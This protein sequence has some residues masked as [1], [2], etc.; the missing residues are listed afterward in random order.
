MPGMFEDDDNHEFKFYRRGRRRVNVKEAV[1]EARKALECP[2]PNLV[3]GL[4]YCEISA[5][6]V[7]L[8]LDRIEAIGEALER[9]EWLEAKIDGMRHQFNAEA[10]K[11]ETLENVSPKMKDQAFHR[12]QRVAY[13]HIVSHLDEL[14]VGK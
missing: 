6:S 7:R 1:E 12:G 14:A 3:E 10:Q 4:D 5:P 11:H 13:G 9:V 2:L 8:I